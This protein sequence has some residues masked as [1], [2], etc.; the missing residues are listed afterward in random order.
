[1]FEIELSLG[2]PYS[3]NRTFGIK[4]YTESVSKHDNVVVF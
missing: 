1:M 3:E 4:D 2:I